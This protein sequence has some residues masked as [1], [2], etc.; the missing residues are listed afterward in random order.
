M[1]FIV[2]LVSA[3]MIW[4]A[5]AFAAPALDAQELYGI[6]RHPDNGSLIQI[7][8]CPTGACGRVVRVG[9]PARRDVYNPDPALRNRPVLGV[10][11]WRN[12]KKIGPHLWAGSLYNTL[13]GG[14]YYGTLHA[15][16]KSTLVLSGCIFRVMLCDHRTWT[17]LKPDAA[18]AV[19]ATMGAK[20]RKKALPAPKTPAKGLEKAAR[21]ANKREVSL[22]KLLTAPIS[23]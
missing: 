1:R 18:R 21:H 10:V 7:Y 6:W 9:D 5:G 8:S 15:T 22:W 17:R 16:G 4:I 11:I 14:T 13:D 23:Q 3:S 2:T 12:G 20:N 19:L